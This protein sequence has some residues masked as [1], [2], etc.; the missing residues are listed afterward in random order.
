MRY[1]A[2]NNYAQLVNAAKELEINF[3]GVNKADLAARINQQLDFL[4]RQAAQVD[5]NLIDAADALTETEYD[6]LVTL[7]EKVEQHNENVK[8]DQRIEAMI[9]A[10]FPSFF[11]FREKFANIA[12]INVVPIKLS[13]F[14]PA[15]LRGIPGINK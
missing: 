15:D 7:L 14:D 13:E 2:N 9:S 4:E 5:L 8:E 6:I 10:A 12:G 11:S 1:S 3:V